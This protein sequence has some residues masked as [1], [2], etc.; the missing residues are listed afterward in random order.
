ML[1]DFLEVFIIISLAFAIL[2][3]YCIIVNKL[4]QK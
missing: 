3:A 1:K 2:E 4:E